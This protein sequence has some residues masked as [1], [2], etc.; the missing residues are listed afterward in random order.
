MYF[1]ARMSYVLESR[2]RP[3]VVRTLVNCSLVTCPV[4]V[5]S[6][7]WKGILMIILLVLT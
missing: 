5:L 6:K 3:K 4:L 7:S 1:L 2:L